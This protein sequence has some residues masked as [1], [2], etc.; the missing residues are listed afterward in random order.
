MHRLDEASRLARASILLLLLLL[1]L[2]A[3]MVH[4]GVR[5]D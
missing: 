2:G 3:R 4:S 1:L 5:P